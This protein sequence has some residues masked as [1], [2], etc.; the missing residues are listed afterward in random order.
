MSYKLILVSLLLVVCSCKTSANKPN[1]PGKK[2]E[3][4][5]PDYGILPESYRSRSGT[6]PLMWRCYPIK[7]V[8][9]KYHSWRAADG[10][11]RSDLIVN[12]CDFEI[13]VN[14]K[15]YQNVYSGRRAKQDVYCKEFRTAWEK[16]TRDE[17]HICI[18]G[19]TLTKGE[20]ELDA[21]SKKMIVSWTWD[22]IKTKKGCYGFWDKYQCVDF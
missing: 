21:D 18:D 13:F 7:D 1:P 17:Y 6:R 9:V 16:L 22:K 2:I 14:S 12:M 8:E 4:V 3:T 19:I 11:G 5:N 20:P 10:M 15:T